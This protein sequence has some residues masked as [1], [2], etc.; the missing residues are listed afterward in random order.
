V[1]GDVTR[2][3]FGTSRQPRL[4]STVSVVVLGALALLFLLLSSW[5]LFAVFAVLAGVALFV[6]AVRRSTG[7]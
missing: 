4:G 3:V 6:R 2:K 5:V 7:R 1:S